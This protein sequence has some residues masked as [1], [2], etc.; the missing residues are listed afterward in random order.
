MYLGAV[1]IKLGIIKIKFSISLRLIEELD[2][3]IKVKELEFLNNKRLWKYYVQLLLLI[4]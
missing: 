1:I 3:S 2:I 4:N